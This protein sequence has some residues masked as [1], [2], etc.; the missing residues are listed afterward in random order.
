MR[1]ERLNVYFERDTARTLEKFAAQQ[2]LKKSAVV[3]AAVRDY[4]APDRADIREA[5]LS[6]RMNRL[7]H[8]LEKIEQDL[9]V[10]TEATAIYIRY[11]LSVVTPIPEAHQEAA[12]AQGKLRF[13]QFIEQLA[14]HLQRGN[15]LARDLHDELFPEQGDFTK[16]A[17]AD[18]IM[19]DTEGHADE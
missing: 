17:S 9:T 18:A 13:S 16:A 14:R 2:N 8:Q 10:L 1:T 4:L 5:A 19:N 6:K 3:E 12:R 11:Y 15:S 7:H